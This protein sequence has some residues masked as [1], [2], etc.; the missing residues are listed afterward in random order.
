MLAHLHWD[1]FNML[2]INFVKNQ[3]IAYLDKEHAESDIFHTQ[4][5]V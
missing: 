4:A 1:V 5:I 2:C 3:P